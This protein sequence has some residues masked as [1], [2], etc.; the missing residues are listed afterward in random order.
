MHPISTRK[1][2]T[3]S[4]AALLVLVTVLAL[5]SASPARAVPVRCCFLYEVEVNGGLSFEYGNGANAHYHG[6]WSGQWGW[7]EKGIF[8]FAEISPSRNE[9]L[10]S[11]LGANEREFISEDDQVKQSEYQDTTMPFGTIYVPNNTFQG[12]A[13]EHNRTV[14]YHSVFTRADSYDPL[15]LFT[16]AAGAHDAIGPVDTAGAFGCGIYAGD[17]G[18]LPTAFHH[19]P[20]GSYGIPAP[21]Y[22]SFSSGEATHSLVCNAS[23]FGMLHSTYS[24]TAQ[25]KASR[26]ASIDIQFFP[27]SELRHYEKSLKTA[28]GSEQV[29]FHVGPNFSSEAITEVTSPFRNPPKSGC[30]A[31]H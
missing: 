29:G 3:A 2:H 19:D 26:T 23:G 4:A 5:A 7:D 27:P 6:D 9:G 21:A 18:N 15:S 20:W 12:P 14:P 25:Y 31:G 24:E 10:L 30:R 28:Y 11:A 13:C 16:G 22:A 8:K 1:W 17:I